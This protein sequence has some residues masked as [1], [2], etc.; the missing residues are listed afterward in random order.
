MR[1]HRAGAPRLPAVQSLLQQLCGTPLLDLHISDLLDAQIPS[2][3]D[4]T[5]DYDVMLF[6]RLE[7][8]APP[9]P[10]APTARGWRHQAPTPAPT[11][12]QNLDTAPVGFAVFDPLLFSVHPADCPVRAR[13]LQ[14]L[15]T[16]STA[17]EK[18]GST[19][20]QPPACQQRRPDAAPARPDG[21]R[22]CSA[23]AATWPGRW[24]S[25]RWPWPQ[26]QLAL[27]RLEQGVAG[28]AGPA[29]AQ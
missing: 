24:S 20:Q 13:H 29:P 4:Y 12:L 28:A 7:G 2:T 9:P 25:G 22:L 21:G 26:P 27:S 6:R 3:F 8:A 23:C 10:P 16:P 11:N 1:A 17:P 18:R 14:R 15:L 5:S 19:G